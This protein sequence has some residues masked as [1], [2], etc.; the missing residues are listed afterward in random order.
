V[1]VHQKTIKLADFGLSKKIGDPIASQQGGLISY[2]DPKK[3]GSN[4]YSLDKK[5]DIY[6]VGVLLWEISS[7]RP[8]FNGKNDYV[9]V[10]QILQGIRETPIPNTPKDYEKIYTGKC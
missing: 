6:S 1:L 10:N 3:F 2:M 8:P 4:S 5:S 9:L 7:C